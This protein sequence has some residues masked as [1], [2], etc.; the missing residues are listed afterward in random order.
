MRKYNFT[1]HQIDTHNNIPRSQCL[2]RCLVFCFIRIV[3]NPSVFCRCCFRITRRFMLRRKT[4]STPSDDFSQL[5]H[6]LMLKWLHFSFH[7]WITIWWAN[8]FAAAVLFQCLASPCV[9]CAYQLTL[10]LYC[11]MTNHFCVTVL[12]EF[13]WDMDCMMQ[14]LSYSTNVSFVTG[15]KN[16]FVGSKHEENFQIL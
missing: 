4:N 12:F 1:I 10:A 2:S 3:A 5:C 6:N 9:V 8:A 16:N 15:Y 11:T 14:K 13:A 7:C